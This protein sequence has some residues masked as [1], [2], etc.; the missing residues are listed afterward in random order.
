MEPAKLY[1]L[2]SLWFTKHEQK[3][4]SFSYFSVFSFGD[5]GVPKSDRKTLA[6]TK[7]RV[8]SGS[9][10]GGHDSGFVIVKK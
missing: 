10:F 6:G 1:F 8:G 3:H 2:V 9:G 4:K 7:P 5:L